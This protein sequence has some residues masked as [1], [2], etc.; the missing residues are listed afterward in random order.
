[1]NLQSKEVIQL[2]N[3]AHLELGLH[4][5]REVMSKFI[6]CRSEDDVINIYLSYYQFTILLFDKKE[7][8]HLVLL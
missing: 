3:H 2:F 4:K 7:F 1:M 8:D 5:L 6:L